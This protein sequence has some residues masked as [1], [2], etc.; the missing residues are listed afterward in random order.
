MC[1]FWVGFS[2]VFQWCCSLVLT[3]GFVTDPSASCVRSWIHWPSAPKQVLEYG[4]SWKWEDTL[5]QHPNL[6]FSKI[7]P[8]WDVERRRKVRETVAPCGVLGHLYSAQSFFKHRVQNK[9]CQSLERSGKSGRKFS[10]PKDGIMSNFKKLIGL[11]NI[12]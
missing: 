9:K 12:L 3:F 4:P 6:W 5:K 8:T 10:H 2:T 7:P 1:S 11:H